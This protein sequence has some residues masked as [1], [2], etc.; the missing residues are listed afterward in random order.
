MGLTI[1]GL[2]QEFL[3][4]S[5]VNCKGAQKSTNVFAFFSNKYVERS[6]LSSSS[7]AVQFMFWSSS[8]ISFSYFSIAMKS[9]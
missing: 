7:S 2:L 1:Q 3:F 4:L 5:E 6:T 8:L 9:R